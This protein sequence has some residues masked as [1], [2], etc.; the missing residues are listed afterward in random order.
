MQQTNNPY[1]YSSVAEEQKQGSK[2]LAIV[3]L[4]LSIIALIGGLCYCV[5]IPFGLAG[6]IISIIVLAAKKNGK[7]MGIASLIMSIVALVVSVGV[8]VALGPI[9]NDMTRF[10]EDLPSIVEDYQEDGSLPDYLEKYRDKYP[11]EFDAFMEGVI[12][13]YEKNPSAFE[14]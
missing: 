7:G 4:V 6:L 8:I 5:A 13:E 3:G 1:Q 11:E 14:Q 12:E 10:Q 2:A 9:A